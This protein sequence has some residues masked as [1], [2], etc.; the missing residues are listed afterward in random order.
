MDIATLFTSSKWDI[1][2][3]LAQE[4]LSPLELSKKLNTSIANISQQMR[5]L[6]FAGLVKKE[7]VSQRDAGKPR[8]LYFLADDFGHICIA[9]NHHAEKKLLKLTTH[10]KILILT[11]M[12]EDSRLHQTIEKAIAKIEPAI[13]QVKAILIDTKTDPCVM[14]IVTDSKEL[15]QQEIETKGQATRIQ[16]RIVPEKDFGK[17]DNSAAMHI[18]H[19]PNG[20]VQK[21]LRENVRGERK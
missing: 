19:D 11:W 9:A 3:L 21:M 5:L 4:K 14:Y 18:L 8:M 1:L 16:L 12:I 13:E 2:Q 7:R 20:T 10:Q 15:K 6:E 17:I